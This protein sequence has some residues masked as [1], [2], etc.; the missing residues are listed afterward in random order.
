MLIAE[1]EAIELLFG[2]NFQPKRTVLLSFGFNEE[3]SG[4]QGAQKLSAFIH[5]RYGDNSLAVIVDEGS[6]YQEA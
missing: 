3:C 2:A 4:K 6:G 5:E 1:L